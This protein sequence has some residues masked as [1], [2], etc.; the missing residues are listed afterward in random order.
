MSERDEECELMH[1]VP[2][3][4]DG[5]VAVRAGEATPPVTPSICKVAATPSS[6]TSN[7]VSSSGGG[8]LHGAGG[9]SQGSLSSRNKLPGPSLTPVGVTGKL[10]LIRR[11]IFIEN[12]DD[13]LEINVISVKLCLDKLINFDSLKIG[14]NKF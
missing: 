13:I 6:P 8:S 1:L 14:E 12:K 9:T 10:Q 3:D 4:F 5:H 2:P 7:K 11:N